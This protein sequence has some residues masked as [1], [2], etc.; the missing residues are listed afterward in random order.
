MK[1]YHS[2][3]LAILFFVV[4]L[5]QTMEGA[6]VGR[7]GAIRGDGV[8]DYARYEPTTSIL[9]DSTHSALTVE[10]WIKPMALSDENE[11]IFSCY[12]RTR[13][14]TSIAMWVDS[15]Q[16][17]NIFKE[18]EGDTTSNTFTPNYVFKVD[19]WYHIAWTYKNGTEV[20]YVNGKPE[21]TQK[22]LNWGLK[23]ISLK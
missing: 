18:E 12:D 20:F 9:H 10:I 16:K 2:I 5:S 15:N 19:T 11:E 13:G 6:T 3:F 23:N 22:V 17:L 7:W 4:V 21:A 8:D 14:R 1:R